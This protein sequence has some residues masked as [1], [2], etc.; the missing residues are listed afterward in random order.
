MTI[1][2]GRIMTRSGEAALAAEGIRVIRF[3]NR[4]VFERSG[5]VVEMIA[6]CF[7]RG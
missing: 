4:M 5:A 7:T 3:E 6:A 2:S 1:R